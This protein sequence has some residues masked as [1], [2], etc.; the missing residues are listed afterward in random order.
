LDDSV[1]ASSSPRIDAYDL[2][3]WK[4]R[5]RSDESFSGER[6]LAHLSALASDAGEHLADCGFSRLVVGTADERAH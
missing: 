3:E 4:V 5:T 1:P 2:H 6:K